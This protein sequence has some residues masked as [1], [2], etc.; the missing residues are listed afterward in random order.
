MADALAD[1][2]PLKRLIR[3]TI[4]PELL[5]EVAAEYAKGRH[6]WWRPATSMR[7]GR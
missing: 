2:A 4:T 7:A 1:N 6:C 3:S 5:R